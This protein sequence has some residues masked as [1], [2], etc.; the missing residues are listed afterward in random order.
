MR[1]GLKARSDAHERRH[2]DWDLGVPGT[3]EQCIYSQDVIERTQIQI[4]NPIPNSTAQYRNVCAHP[5]PP[6]SHPLELLHNNL[7]YVVLHLCGDLDGDR[8]L[9]QSAIRAFPTL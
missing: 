5:T 9:D 4:T 3:R 8:P 2:R 6:Y 1:L 7:F